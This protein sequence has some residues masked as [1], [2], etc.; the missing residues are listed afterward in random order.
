MICFDALKKKVYNRGTPPLT[1]LIEM[2][3]WGKKTSADIFESRKD[4][5]GE[6]DI[7]TSVK[8][9]L[10][11]WDGKPNNTEFILHRKAVML[12]VMRVLAGFESSWNWKEGRD[13]TNSTSVTPTTIEA[14]AWQVS[15][16]S[17]VFGSDLQK[18]VTM[19][20][21]TLDGNAFQRAMKTNHE[22]AME[23]IA[24]LLR[25][26]IRHNGPVKRGEIHP[27]LERDAVTE[28]KKLLTTS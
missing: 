26:T 8:I 21:G 17:L 19:K 5:P 10:G 16:N 20:V 4:D 2:V 25:H 3:E 22:L 24:R 23:Y 13:I 1:F 12:E 11:P 28:W 7:Y 6:T 18:L 9:R 14:G 27:Y 15:A